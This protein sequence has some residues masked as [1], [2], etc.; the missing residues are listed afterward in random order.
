M[1]ESEVD[2]AVSAVTGWISHL[3]KHLQRKTNGPTSLYCLFNKRDE[4]ADNLL[5]RD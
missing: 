2:S 3:D 1:V 4:V 5:Q